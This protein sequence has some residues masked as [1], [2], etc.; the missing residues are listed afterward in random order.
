MRFGLAR[1]A[2]AAAVVATVWCT[3]AHATVFQYKF[4]LDGPS[5]NPV[6]ASPGTGVGFADYDSV[7]RTLTMS[8]TFS[9]LIGT[10]TQTHFHGNAT[11]PIGLP[12][13]SPPWSD[14]V[15]QATAG[16]TGNTGI[17]IGAPSLPGFPLGGTSGVY[18]HVL[19]LTD[20]TVYNATFLANNGGTAAGAE[21]AF[22]SALATGRIYWNVH[23]TQFPGGEIRGFGFLIPEPAG[24]SLLAAGL[25]VLR[26]RRR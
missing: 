8:A 18:N 24:A 6:N 22:A 3:S 15:R 13:G 11:S 12:P 23:S 25:L 2:A 10:V 14:A 26:R 19:D 20:P 7:A 17:A 16:A 1:W 5:E 4:I 9:G 21:A